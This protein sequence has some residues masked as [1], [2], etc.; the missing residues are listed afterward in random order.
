MPEFQPTAARLVRAAQ[1]D[2]FLRGYLAAIEWLLDEDQEPAQHGFS[3]A[4][5]SQ[6]VA[7]CQDFRMD[8]VVDLDIYLDANGLTEYQAGID[9]YL[10]RCSHGSGYFDRGN[11]EVFDRLQQAARSHGE[12]NSWVENGF[13]E[14]E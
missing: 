5:V 6:A 10:S 9:F 11:G 1:H 3:E 8:N 13:I 2:D 7:D 12:V 14:V 4:T